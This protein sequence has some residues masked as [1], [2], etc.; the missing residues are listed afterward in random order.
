M[1]TFTFKSSGTTQADA[2]ANQL[3][4]TPPVIGILTPLALGT[5]DLLVTSTDLAI[6]LQDNLRNLILTDWGER[7]CL[8]DYGANLGPLM[9]DLVSLDDFDSQAITRIKKAVQR[10]MPYIDL[11]DFTSADDR[12][13]NK[14]T[15]V[16]ILTI[17]YNIPS[18][19]ITNKKLSVTLRAL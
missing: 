12:S 9:S 4:V 6:Q 15:A 8:Y 1:G 11:V 5:T 18:L 19:G 14:S 3:A 16:I 13:S 17:T 2:V 10:W 7:L